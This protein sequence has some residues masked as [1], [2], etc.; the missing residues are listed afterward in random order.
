[1][2]EK[3]ENDLIR[4][5]LFDAEK[6]I[7]NELIKSIVQKKKDIKENFIETS[8]QLSQILQRENHNMQH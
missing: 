6:N 3:I 5:E 8:E 4:I 7:M 2:E 1:L